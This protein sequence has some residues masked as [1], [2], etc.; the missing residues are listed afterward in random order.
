[1]VPSKEGTN[2]EVPPLCG[3]RFGLYSATKSLDTSVKRNQLAFS[4]FISLPRL[5]RIVTQFITDH[6]PDTN[7]SLRV[8]DKRPRNYY[9]GDGGRYADDRERRIVVLPLICLTVIYRSI[10]SDNVSLS[11]S[12]SLSLFLRLSRWKSDA[13]R[14]SS[15]SITLSERCRG[16]FWRTME[17]LTREEEK[18]KVGCRPHLSPR[19]NGELQVNQRSSGR[20]RDNTG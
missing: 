4:V 12:L 10:A 9:H 7:P 6:P 18:V 11:L 13:K 8:A 15:C 3:D 5:A 16:E 2:R 1:M 20:W 19:I 17:F 14:K